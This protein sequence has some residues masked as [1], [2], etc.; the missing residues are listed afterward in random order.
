M[1]PMTLFWLLPDAAAPLVIVG[2][3]VALMMGLLSKSRAISLIGQFLLA[4]TL[5][6]LLIS[7]AIGAVVEVVPAG[8]L[9]AAAAI[10]VPIALW[11]G[12]RTVGNFVLGKEA[13]G[14]LIA[15]LVLASSGLLRRR[16]APEVFLVEVPAQPAAQLPE[17]PDQPK[18]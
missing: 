6:P 16:P 3:G 7:V 2:I 15:R 11:A 17:P 4:I 5:G 1:N 14:E 9:L 12:F 10:I 13:M 18:R 8:W